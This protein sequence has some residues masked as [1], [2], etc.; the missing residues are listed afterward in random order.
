MRELVVCVGRTPLRLTGI[1]KRAVE[2]V[3]VLAEEELC[4]T[5][6]GEAR[7]QVLEVYRMTR[8]KTLSH[9]TESLARVILEDA[10]VGNA[11]AREEWA[12]NAAVELPYIAVRVE[13]TRAQYIAILYACDGTYAP[14]SALGK[15][16]CTGTRYLS[17]SC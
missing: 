16:T 11:V 8:G 12:G 10:E 17:R 13:D 2:R 14:R 1:R 5:I 9:R 7:D 4:R 15:T 3:D 6:D